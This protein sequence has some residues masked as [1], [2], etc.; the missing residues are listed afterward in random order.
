MIME[1]E[2]IANVGSNK[3]VSQLIT[4]Y[5]IGEFGILR[6]EVKTVYNLLDVNNQPL[7]NNWFDIYHIQEDNSIIIGYL[8]SREEQEALTKYTSYTLINDILEKYKYRYGAINPE[9]K[10]IINPLIDYLEYGNES[11]LLGTYHEKKG[12]FS[13]LDGTQITPMCF[14][15]V[16]KYQEGLACV[17]FT[18]KYGYIDK[19]TMRNPSNRS[20][21]QIPADFIEATDF[22]DGEASVSTKTE[23]FKIDKQGNKKDIKK[24]TLKRNWYL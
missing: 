20:Q 19:R 14:I 15:K 21:Y 22:K 18:E 2:I 8:R 11:T 7:I 10:L 4:S 6:P 17:M 16:H 9:G 1:Y 24:L 12:F 3:L 13:S 5:T 23:S